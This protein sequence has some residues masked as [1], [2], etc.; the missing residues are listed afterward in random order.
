V[1]YLLDTNICIYLMKDQPCTIRAR[2]AQCFYGDV[3]ISTI[4]LAELRFGV[5]KSAERR[6]WNDQALEALLED[7]VVA[8]FDDRAAAAYGI[9]RAGAPKG[10]KDALDKLIASQ[11]ITLSVTLVTNNERDFL[12]YPGVI[13]ENWLAP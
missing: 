5:E 7:L 4:T 8:P 9:L 6:A 2:F 12:R 11:T 13:V 3:G 10:R 1:K